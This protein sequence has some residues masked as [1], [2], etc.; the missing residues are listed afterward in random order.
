MEPKTLANSVMT[1]INLL[2]TAVLA[3]VSKN[4]AGPAQLASP[5]SAYKSSFVVIQSLNFLQKHVMMAIKI[6]MTAAL[7][8][9]PLS[10]ALSALQ[11][12]VNATRFAEMVRS[13]ET[14]HVMI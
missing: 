6:L 3:L 10:L 4:L 13:R 14:K 7:V 12:L 1:P 8:P 9:V 11:L 2:E 5:L